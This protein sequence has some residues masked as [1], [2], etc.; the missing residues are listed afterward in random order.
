[1]GVKDPN[2]CKRTVVL[3]EKVFCTG[4]REPRY[5]PKSSLWVLE[6]RGGIR[7]VMFPKRKHTVMF[8]T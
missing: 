4:V 7:K 1:M 5:Y 6:T 2:R 8:I 3:S